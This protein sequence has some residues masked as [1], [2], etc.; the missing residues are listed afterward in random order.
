MKRISTH[1]AKK[2]LAFLWIV[3]GA[4]LFIILILQSMFGRFGE[5]TQEAWSWFLPTIVPTLSLMIG[6]LVLEAR[7]NGGSQK[8]VD[9]Y[10]YWLSLW[11]SIFYL[12]VVAMTP[13]LQPFTGTP[14]FKLMTLS[15]LWLAPLQGLTAAALGIFFVKGEEEKRK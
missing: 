9:S 13:L 15:N 10:F 2:R 8:T 7:T 6:A 4:V 12:V 5:R 14:P 1:T 11:L 3:V